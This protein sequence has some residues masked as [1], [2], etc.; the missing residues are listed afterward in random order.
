M[1]NNLKK[2]WNASPFSLSSCLCCRISTL[3]V[4]TRR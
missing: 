3:H 2:K 4:T 1:E